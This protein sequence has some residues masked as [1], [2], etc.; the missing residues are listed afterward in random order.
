MFRILVITSLMLFSLKILA[1][2]QT[3]YQAALTDWS[4]VLKTYVDDQGRTDFHA[5]SDDL[6]ALD[7]VV[8]FIGATSP[9]SH[10]ELFPTAKAVMAYHINAYNALAMR[11]VIDWEVP[12]G[13]TTLWTRA[14]FFK[15]R[16]VTIG[17]KKTNLY[18]YENKVIRPLDEPRSHFALNCMV[19]DCPRLPQEPFLVDTLDQQLDAATWEFFS[20]ERHFYLDDKKKRAHV[21][22]ILDF[23]TKDFVKSG[24]AKDLPEYIN[25]YLKQPIPA[26]YKVEF[27]DYDWR[28][29]QQPTSADL[30]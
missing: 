12:K 21:S 11:G 3:E 8:A 6:T 16:N 17:G 25:R 20:K 23:Y 13:F 29:N 5:L 24:K 1:Q 2:T 18:D 15:F 28:I 19:K 10:P 4:Y 22:A 27:I 9:A 26:G 7:R 30:D 14:R